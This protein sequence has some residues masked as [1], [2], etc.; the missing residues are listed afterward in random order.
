M[1]DKK[2]RKLEG[3]I[4]QLVPPIG[5]C[6]ASD[7]ITVDGE[8]IG[9]MYREL[10]YDKIDSGWR[11]FAGDEDRKYVDNPDNFALYHV[12]TIANFDRAIIPY[13]FSPVGTS[14]ERIIE[15]DDFFEI[16]NKNN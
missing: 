8:K 9:Y 7:R 3:G 2:F 14:F 6:C 15:T 5:S 13:L 11:F 10:P 16:I 4:L 1:K 12:N